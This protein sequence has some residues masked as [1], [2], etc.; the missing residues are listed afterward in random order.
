MSEDTPPKH[1]GGASVGFGWGC[2]L[3]A[4]YEGGA[5]R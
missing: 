5:I 4:Q 3:D 1:R 2:Y